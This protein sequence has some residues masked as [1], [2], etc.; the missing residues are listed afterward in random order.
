MRLSDRLSKI[1]EVTAAIAIVSILSGAAVAIIVPFIS[2]RLE[3]SR[4]R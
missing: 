1:E 2:A 4:M 3:R